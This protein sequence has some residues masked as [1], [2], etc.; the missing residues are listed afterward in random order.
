MIDATVEIGGAFGFVRA[1][2]AYVARG[3]SATPSKHDLDDNLL[4]IN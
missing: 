2:P 4:K 3:L 1:A